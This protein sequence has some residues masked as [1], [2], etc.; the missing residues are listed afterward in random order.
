MLVEHDDVDEMNI[1]Y[2]LVWKI[3]V[4]AAAAAAAVVVD[5]DVAVVVVI[6]VHCC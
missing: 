2:L 4:L 6:D 1:E 5:D 3:M